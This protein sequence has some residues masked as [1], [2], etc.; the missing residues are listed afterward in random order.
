MGSQG[1]G[2][3]KYDNK[4]RTKYFSLESCGMNPQLLIKSEF[5][6]FV[7]ISLQKIMKM[8]MDTMMH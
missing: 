2:A 8:T 3:P 4:N 5:F 1:V 6:V 7:R